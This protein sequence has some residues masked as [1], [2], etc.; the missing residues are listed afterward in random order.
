MQ[1]AAKDADALVWIEIK[2]DSQEG[3]DQLKSYLRDL[4]DLGGPTDK[5]LVYLTRQGESEAPI[6]ALESEIAHPWHWN[7][8]MSEMSLGRGKDNA[9]RRALGEYLK[10]VNAQVEPLHPTS[11]EDPAR[12]QEL[13]VSLET[14][15]KYVR[16]HVVHVGQNDGWEP[17]D[18]VPGSRRSGKWLEIFPR[19]WA[20]YQVSAAGWENCLLEWHLCLA[21]MGDE[22]DPAI[23]PAFGAGLTYL[24]S[25]DVEADTLFAGSDL[26][27]FLPVKVDGWARRF[28]FLPLKGLEGAGDIGEQQERLATFVTSAFRDLLRRQR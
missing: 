9:V 2:L 18:A 4:Q 24:R 27:D 1:L 10:E 17:Y 26:A 5:H 6:K 20:S 11:L 8:L 23:D 7:A 13:R 19:T 16:D 21:G 14:A 22:I 25:N 15:A 3:P 12:F 28:R